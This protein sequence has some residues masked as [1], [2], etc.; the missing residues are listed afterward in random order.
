[1]RNPDLAV[2]RD[3]QKLGASVLLINEDLPEGST[4]LVLRVPPVPYGWQFL[5][6]IVPAQLAAERL[7]RLLGVDSDTFRFC[8]YIV[9]GEYGLSTDEVAG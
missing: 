8:S 2:A 6:D 7:A 9:R 1:M 5:F 4:D 3:L